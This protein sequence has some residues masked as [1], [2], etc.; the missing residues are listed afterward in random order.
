MTDL[1]TTYL[2]LTLR[3]PLV[4]SSSSATQSVD[5]VRALADA[6][7]RGGRPALA[8]RGAGHP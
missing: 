5:R 4:A 7:H 8:V 2:G 3:N 1:T 6:G